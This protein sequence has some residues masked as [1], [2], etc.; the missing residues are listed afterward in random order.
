MT[1]GVVLI[2]RLELPE[3]VDE[4]IGVRTDVGWRN[5]E[6][7]A[8]HGGDSILDL[9]HGIRL[10]HAAELDEQSAAGGDRHF[11]VYPTGQ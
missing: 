4:P 10:L 9:R 2:V 8:D 7:A 11:G 1:R 5:R 3:T 6:A